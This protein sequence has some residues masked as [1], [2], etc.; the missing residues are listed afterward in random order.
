MSNKY[1]KNNSHLGD[2]VIHQKTIPDVPQKNSNSPSN[3]LASQMNATPSGI[4]GRTA[5]ISKQLE[6]MLS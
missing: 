5:G 1:L 4:I 6:E 2:I 3:N